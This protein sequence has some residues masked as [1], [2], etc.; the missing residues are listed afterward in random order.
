MQQS[1]D[2]K[3]QKNEYGKLGLTLRLHR[4]RL[5]RPLPSRCPRQPRLAHGNV[6]QRRPRLAQVN[7]QVTVD[8]TQEVDTQQRQQ[9]WEPSHYRKNDSKIVTIRTQKPANMPAK[10]PTHA[11]ARARASELANYLAAAMVLS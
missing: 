6:A 5:R 2:A 1:Q 8:R 10:A 9:A 3:V 7:V 4:C 11:R